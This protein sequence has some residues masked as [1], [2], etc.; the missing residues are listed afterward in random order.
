MTKFDEIKESISAEL[1]KLNEI[2]N[3]SLDSSS[4]LLNEIVS[5][6]L[7]TKGKQI[8]PIIVILSAGFFSG[9]NDNTLNAAAAIELLH[10][11]S[12]I[13]DDVVDETKKRRGNPTINSVWDNHIAVLV[14]DFFV[15]N[16]LSCAIQ[17]GDMRVITTI[18]QLGKE[19]SIGEL[20]QI[21]VAKH[22]S[23]TEENYYRI[24]GKKTA[25]LFKSCVQVGGYT[26][27]APQS[28]I[29]NLARFVEL[30]GLCF[31]IKDDIFDYFS[32]KEVGKPTGNDLREGNVTLPLIYALS[33]A[34]SPLH[35][36][37]K[38]LVMRDVLEN[39]DIERLIEFAKSEGGIE[40]AYSSMA[41]L[42]DEAC[43]VLAPYPE[44]CAKRAF[45]DLFDYIIER[46]N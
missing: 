32:D 26:A 34:D 9:V 2:I 4:P 22:H 15:S 37:M 42:K 19:L 23:I 44:S 14:G 1:S 17:S 25:S 41:R 7:K 45:I 3:V 33:K 24:I 8:R 46:H 30:L 29:D 12:L 40:Y 10:N 36:E 20:D 27:K 39:D 21:D 31:Q 18:S 5:M 35:R 13:H 6:Y 28:D 16:A 11:A 38:E 43:K